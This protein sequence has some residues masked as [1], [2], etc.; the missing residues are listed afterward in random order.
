TSQPTSNVVFDIV[1]GDPS[2]GTVGPSSLTF[3]TANWD[4]AQTVNVTAV[5]DAVADGAQVYDITISVDAPNSDNSFN[6]LADKTVTV[7]N[8]DDDNVGINITPLILTTT[9]GGT[10]QTFSLVLNSAPTSNVVVLATSLD[11]TEGVVSPASLTFSPANWNVPRT[12]TVTPVNDDIVDGDQTYNVRLRIDD[13]NS[14]DSFDS[15]ADQNVVVTNT[16]NDSVGINIGPISG[17]T[18][19]AG[20]TANFLVTLS[21][22]PTA[23]VT[24]ALSSSD[25][26]EGAVA[27][28]VVIP[29]ADWQMGVPVTVTGV[30]D[31]TVDGNQNYTIITGNVTSADANYNTISGADVADV[32]VLNL[33]IDQATIAINT[34][35]VT[36]N[37]GVGTAVLTVTLFGNVANSFTVDYATQN[38][39][40]TAGALFDYMAV[41]GEL[42]FV[43][44]NGESQNIVVDINDDLF[45]EP[46]ETFFVNV[47]NVE[48][49]GNITIGNASA[50]VSITDN[51]S[52]NITIDDVIVAENQSEAVFTLTL[53]GSS[54]GSFDVNYNTVDGT[55]IAGEDYTSVTGAVTFSGNDGETQTVSVPIINDNIVELEDESFTLNLSST[56]NV[57]V[58]IGDG[59]GLGTI[60]DDETCPAGPI[61]PVLNTEVAT[62]FCDVP[63][64]DLNAYTNSVPPAGT[65][66]TWST[67][68]IDLTDEANHL[69]SS[70]V[71]SEFPGTYYGFFYDAVNG[72][73]SPALEITLDFKNSPII[74]STTGA[75]RCGE[76]T[77]VLEAIVDEGI[78]NWYAAAIGGPILGTGTSFTTPIL[79][80]TTTY[81]VASSE[82]GCNSTRI[83]VIAAVFPE[84]S[85]GVPSNTTACSI[86][87]DDGPTTVALDNQLSDADSGEWVFSSGPVTT[88]EI[89]TGNIVDFEG[90]ANG[91]YLFTY[92]TNGAQAPCTNS[93]VSITIS[94]SDCTIDTDN[95]GIIDD[96]EIVLGTDPNNADS[97]GDGI[98]DGQEV[99]DDVNNPIDTDGDGIIDALD[100]NILDSDNDGI[101]DQLDPANDNPCIPNISSACIIDLAIV[102]T[103]N[104]QSPRLGDQVVYTIAVSNLS[105]TA[106]NTIEINDPISDIAGLEYISHTASLGSFNELSGLWEIDS[107]E[108]GETVRLE[109]TLLTIA[110][111]N[112][113]NTATVSQSQPADSNV[114][115][116]T[117]SIDIMVNPPDDIDL[118]L[119]KSVDK[120]NP[121]V[122]DE[123][124]FTIL[125][126][127]NS[128]RRVTAVRIN[129][130]IDSSIGF[131]YVSHTATKGTYD[132]IVGV[133]ELPEILGNEMNTLEIRVSVP[134]EGSFRNTVRIVDTFPNDN[135]EDNNIAFV[136]IIVGARSNGESGFVFNQ[137][138]PNNDGI[139]DVLKINDIQSYPNTTLEIYDRYGNQVFAT[140]K[141][142][143]TWSGT[144][145]NG[146][147]PKGTY[148]YILHLGEGTQ[149]KKGWLQIIR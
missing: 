18:S 62:V 56:T 91:D 11:T 109:I 121:L 123:I 33:D 83:P 26:A 103:V 89:G 147:L 78:L 77:V 57:L 40:A 53:T 145:K 134:I 138:S 15:L 120:D 73:A 54:I 63:N 94:V 125:L 32:D 5:D 130:L 132:E 113:T 47:S 122:G 68:I 98:D 3:T 23:P 81:Y 111:G 110:E 108:M 149:V 87:S 36:V 126:T 12:V 10:S 31:N 39:T 101:V 135:N 137:I 2:E 46:S 97:D 66:L 79:T 52:A 28:N 133:W 25:T 112:Y 16:D 90:L 69:G 34:T 43:G 115:N 59:E 129:E 124:V 51:D 70:I 99:G 82:D 74:T 75:E 21:S 116:N 19:E 128:P 27:A 49:I 148:F 105:Q 141:Y 104:N 7:T 95:D 44:N 107:I 96:N 64:Q 76:G 24:I 144:G 45:V 143:N 119:E 118:G 142:D 58:S 9:E 29:I 42:S 48:G 14:D 67:D 17:N 61:A 102:K 20:T 136:D 80:A 50:T 86:V 127:N 71:D 4:T 6:A 140:K 41:N 65:V 88:I 8:T 37:E 13:D 100:S 35:T 55:A 38:N 131:E 93:S 85:P 92:T 114:A 117:S 84:V 1:S 22:E 106:I 60:L 146:D 139:N 30:A 72:C